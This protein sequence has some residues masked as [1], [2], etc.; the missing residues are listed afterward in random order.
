MKKI[1]LLTLLMLPLQVFASTGFVSEAIM[2]QLFTTIHMSIFVLFPLAN[3]LSEEGELK[4]LFIKLF[5]TR[6][7]I[8]LVFDLFIPDV[9]L[10]IDF[11]AIF[12]GAFIVVPICAVIT[13]KSPFKLKTKPVQNSINVIKKCQNC[14]KFKDEAGS[15]SFF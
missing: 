9:M 14:G 10:S 1:L 2:I 5:V 8:L 11:F 13:K 15:Y 4:S 12:I 7:V 3:M 6:A